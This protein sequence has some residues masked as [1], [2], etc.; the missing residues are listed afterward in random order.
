M[1]TSI[2]SRVSS[3]WVL[4]SIKAGQVGLH[5]GHRQVS[6]RW[7]GHPLAGVRLLRVASRLRSQQYRA[8]DKEM[9]RTWK[10]SQLLEQEKNGRH[11]AFQKHGSPSSQSPMEGVRWYLVTWKKWTDVWVSQNGGMRSLIGNDIGRVVHKMRSVQSITLMGGQTL[12]FTFWW[13]LCVIGRMV[14]T[15]PCKQ[16]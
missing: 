5:C 10:L 7:K 3:C 12:E 11:K 16:A 1:A 14:Q 6:S 15:Q 8:R 2:C 4:W 9:P 13:W